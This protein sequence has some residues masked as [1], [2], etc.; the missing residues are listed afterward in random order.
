M[1]RATFELAVD[2]LIYLFNNNQ[3]ELNQTGKW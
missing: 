3:T 2:Y 1:L